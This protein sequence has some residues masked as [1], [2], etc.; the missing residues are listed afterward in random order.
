M[1]GSFV[2]PVSLQRTSDHGDLLP[3]DLHPRT[4]QSKR[5]GSQ[6]PPAGSQL[7]PAGVVRAAAG[8]CL[9]HYAAVDSK[10]NWVV[11]VAFNVQQGKVGS[12][13]VDIDLVIDQPIAPELPKRRPTRKVQHSDL[14]QLFEEQHFPEPVYYRNVDCMSV[15]GL[16]TPEE[17]Q[18]II[19]IAESRGSFQRQCRLRL[20]DVRTLDVVDQ[21]FAEAIWRLAGLGWLLRTVSVDGLVPCGISEVMRISKYSQGGLFAKHIDRPIDRQDGRVSKYSVRIFLNDCQ[22]FGGGLSVFHVPFQTDPVVFEPERGLALLYP[23]G[24]L[25]TLQE[26]TE[27]GSGVKYVLRADVLFCRPEELH[28]HQ[29]PFR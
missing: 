24:E 17:C 8:A 29:T 3:G 11:P 10:G 21:D 7:P 15:P 13:G 16:L 28:E 20:L 23:Q 2:G 27:V 26:E 5:G 25:C 1:R 14:A 12:R 22:D 9:Q 19:D 6:M 4:S 18:G